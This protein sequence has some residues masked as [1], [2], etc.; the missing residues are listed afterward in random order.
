LELMPW[1]DPPGPEGQ[2]AG[3]Q[4]PEVFQLEHPSARLPGGLRTGALQFGVMPEDP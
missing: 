3:Q 4:L 1:P 2:E